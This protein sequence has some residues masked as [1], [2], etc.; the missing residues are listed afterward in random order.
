MRASVSGNGSMVNVSG[1][2]LHH[3]LSS[4]ML[5]AVLRPHLH[6]IRTGTALLL[7]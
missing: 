7:S 5:L 6:D 2:M 3:G 4:E 1:N